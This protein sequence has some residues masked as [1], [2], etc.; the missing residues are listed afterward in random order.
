MSYQLEI[1]RGTNNAFGIAVKDENGAAYTLEVDQ[2]LVFALKPDPLN[3][4][5]KNQTADED[6]RVL[7]KPITRTVNG[8]YYLELVPSDTANLLP[9]RYF[10]D[11]GMQQGGTVFYNIIKASP[12][13]IL[14]N[15]AK[16]GDV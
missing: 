7:V 5:M 13:M 11:V 8:E 1:V 10:Y 9:G 14:P 12:F 3:P 6:G 4:N 16:L 2:T 15:V